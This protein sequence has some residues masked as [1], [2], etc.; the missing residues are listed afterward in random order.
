MAH[1]FVDAIAAAGA[2]A[3]KFQT[4]IAAAES[5]AR[6]PWRTPFSS[7]DESRFH[8]WRRMEFSPAQW[9]ELKRHAE[10]RGL[11]FLSSPFSIEA[12]DLLE[13]MGVPAWKIASG[14]LGNGPMLE[15]LSRT[16]LP[17]LISCGMSPL[18][19]IDAS[20]M[21]L[22]SRAIPITVLQ[23]TST[24]PCPPAQVGLN[25]I[26]FFRDR[27]GCAVGLSDHSGTIFPGLA[28]SMLGIDALEVHVTLTREMFGP[29]VATSVTTTE[30]RQMI[31][32]VRFIEEM[33]AN[34]V[35]KDIC[36]H[37]L[38]P[39]RSIFMKSVVARTPLPRGTILRQ[40]HVALKKP[41]TGIPASRTQD[42]IGKRLRRPVA[43][44]ELIE[45]TDLESIL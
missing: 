2:D 24:Y 22:K 7:Q 39:L 1:A 41:G 20:V 43:V 33:R 14:E 12:A 21:F 6:E 37:E 16:R 28:A 35:D 23:C 5:T 10:S 8:Y 19:E 3:V 27:Y 15:R 29:D 9:L 34:P 13:E 30:L 31:E 26:P 18:S 45:E 38:A 11:M 42:V 44:D 25:L 40:E 17:M 4:H 32:G 36:A